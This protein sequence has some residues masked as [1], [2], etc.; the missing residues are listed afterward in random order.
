MCPRRRPSV[1]QCDCDPHHRRRAPQRLDRRTSP[2][3][4]PIAPSLRR[5]RQR[6]AE[7]RRHR[8]GP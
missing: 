1:A 4:D 6:S 2:V 3:F 8:L 5:V 7:P